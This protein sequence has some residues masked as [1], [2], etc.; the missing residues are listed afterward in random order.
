M[1]VR[2]AELRALLTRKG[3][4]HYRLANELG[5]GESTLCRWLRE[6]L[7]AELKEKALAAIERIERGERGQ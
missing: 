3:I 6:E 5:I 4:K 7:P 2:N 1:E